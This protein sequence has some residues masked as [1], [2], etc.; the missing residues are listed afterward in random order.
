MAARWPEFR[1]KV[2]A[3]LPSGDRMVLDYA[4]L[5]TRLA[6]GAR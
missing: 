1:T 2:L 5:C 3:Q 4:D 6:A